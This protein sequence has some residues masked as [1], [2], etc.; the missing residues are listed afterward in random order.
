MSQHIF[1]DTEFSGF[2]DPQLISIGLVTSTGE[3]FYAE[4]N[5]NLE[6]CSDFV[7]QTVIPLLT[8]GEKVSLA[9]LK[10]SL[11]AWIEE[12][13]GEGPTLLCYDSEYD[14]KMLESIFESDFPNG[15]VLRNLGATYV[16]KLKQYE[17]YV[18]SKEAEHHALHD[19]RALKYAFRGWV[20]KVR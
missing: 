6:E 18:K 1:I 16:N 2:K 15:V 5:F 20:R 9:D 12:V 10:T 11:S 4:V 8:R 13:R 17:Y 19:A 3:E 7:R 14:R